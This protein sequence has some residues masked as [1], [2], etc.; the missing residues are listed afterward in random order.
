MI[1][2]GPRV[3][4]VYERNLSGQK[5]REIIY[6]NREEAVSADKKKKE[7]IPV[8]DL[9]DDVRKR[10]SPLSPRSV[11]SFTGFSPVRPEA[12]ATDPT[13]KKKLL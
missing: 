4:P 8:E 6:Q 11:E 13:W 3:S 2:N 9:V 7:K 5:S 1:D 10:Y 12:D